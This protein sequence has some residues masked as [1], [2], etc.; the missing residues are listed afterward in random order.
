MKLI[1]NRLIIK[2]IDITDYKSWYKG[3]NDREASKNEFDDGFIDMSICTEP[4]FE[5][6]VK[7][8]T[9]MREDDYQYIYSIFD[10]TGN[11]L[12]MIDIVTLERKNFQWAEIGYFIHNQ[13]WRNGYAFEALE[14][15]LDFT[16]NELKF[17]RIEAHVSVG[18]TPSIKLLEKLNFQYEGIR[19]QFIFENGEWKDKIIYSKILYCN[20]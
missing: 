14:S 6:L 16:A 8:H 17:H 3:F 12:W 7:K 15:I 2:E 4:W 1:T 5:E 9:K 13:F 11:H 10:K 18:N 19:K 20:K